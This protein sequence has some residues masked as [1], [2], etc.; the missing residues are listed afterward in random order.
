MKTLISTIAIALTVTAVSAPASAQSARELFAL[1]QDSA[2]ERIVR[3]GSIGDVV[4]TQNRLA[5]DNDSAAEQIVRKR[6]S[7]VTRSS[8]FSPRARQRSDS[9]RARFALDLDSAAERYRYN[10]N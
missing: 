7:N 2:A 9:A 8:L 3:R 1:D 6:A 10:K 4:G 5:A